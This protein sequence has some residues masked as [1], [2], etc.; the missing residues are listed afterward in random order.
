MC[1]R[2]R[3]R[4]CGG[5]QASFRS[6]RMPVDEVMQREDGKPMLKKLATLATLVLIVCAAPVAAADEMRVYVGTYTGKGGSK[7]IYLLKLDPATGKLS[8][9][10]LAGETVNPSYVA[11]G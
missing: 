3:G 10:E 2:H 8:T 9:P 6:R 7:G 11:L 1:P 5:R 4:T